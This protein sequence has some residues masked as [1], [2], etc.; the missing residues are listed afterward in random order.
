MKNLAELDY[1]VNFQIPVSLKLSG[2]A[3]FYRNCHLYLNIEEEGS[4]IQV[5]VQPKDIPEVEEESDVWIE[6]ESATD[7]QVKAK[8]SISH[9]WFFGGYFYIGVVALIVFI[10]FVFSWKARKAPKEVSSTVYLKTDTVVEMT[11]APGFT[12][13]RNVIGVTRHLE[14]VQDPLPLIMPRLV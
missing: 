9:C 6:D 12:N 14:S 13:T 3:D 5:Q 7:D 11:Q 10:I 2:A 8:A 1:S 4:F